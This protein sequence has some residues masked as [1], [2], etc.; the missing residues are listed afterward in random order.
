MAD[1]SFK[2][3]KSRAENVYKRYEAH[4]GGKPRAT[5]D[6]DLLDELIDELDD[7]VDQA[8]ESLNGGRNPAMV[9]LLDMA[10]KNRGVYREEREAIVEAKEDGPTSRRASRLSTEANLTFGRY[11]RHFANE[12]R[13]TRDTGLLTELI[14]EIERIRGEMQELAD[15][16]EPGLESNLEVV[17]E[18]LE[19]YRDE[20]RAIEEAQQQG[21][22]Q[23]QADVLAALANAQ[24]AIYRAHFAGKPRPTRRPGLLE[25]VVSQLKRIHK[26]MFELKQGGL[27]SES[28]ERNM[29]IVS[30]NL[31]VY[32]SEL[33]QIREARD[34][35]TTEQL[36]GSLGGE[37]NEVMEE[38]RRDFAGENRRTR[39]L[40]QLSL[41]CDRMCEI[42]YQ[43]RAIQR[44]EPSD[45]NA[46][47]FSIVLDS[48]TMYEEEYRKVE[49]AQQQT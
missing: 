16:G 30:K 21:T 47:N 25:R 39:D 44:D 48:W 18:N 2:A 17:E 9:S 22:A 31:D 36:V 10:Q 40:E 33:D 45:I 49:K 35:V 41:I 8:K 11:Y 15:Q 38:Y 28:N 42:A 6:L 43:M 14:V 24:F 23:E 5:R 1:N 13:R 27:G 34:A 46:K 3:L 26:R 7:I 32:Q 4:F 37:A 29:E 12:D 20:Y 19:M